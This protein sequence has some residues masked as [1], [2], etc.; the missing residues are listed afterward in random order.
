MTVLNMHNS[1]ALE[2]WLTKATCGL[3]AASADRVR[4]EI[5]DHYESAFETAISSG[6]SA[7]DADRAA[8]AALGDAKTAN[9]QYRRVLLTSSEARMLREGNWEARAV[10][11]HTWMKW[12]L[13]AI[14]AAMLLA[15]TVLYLIGAASG[16][17]VAFA[18][19]IGLG[20]ALA[21]PLLPIYTPLRGRIYRSVKWVVLFGAIALALGPDVLKLSWLFSACFWPLAWI[22][23]TRMS[24]RRKLPVAQWP[25]QLYL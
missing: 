9:R 1:P 21:A 20:V 17:R 14:P 11:S 12:L 10:C 13:P 23:L 3:A 19:A 7:D 24:I 6:A 18:G 22:E 25:K 2:N 8:V 4:S 5:R 16:A 15:A